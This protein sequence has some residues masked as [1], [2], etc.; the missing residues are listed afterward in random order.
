MPRLPKWGDMT[1]EQCLN[2]IMFGIPAP[3]KRAFEYMS[4][5]I[6]PLDKKW[7]DQ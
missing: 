5:V 7:V 3:P 4:E 1:F 2:K 6:K